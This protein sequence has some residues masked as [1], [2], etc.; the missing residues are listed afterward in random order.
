MI[1]ARYHIIRKLLI[2]LIAKALYYY[3]TPY[4]EERDF[5]F[6]RI[7]SLMIYARLTATVAEGRFDSRYE[8]ERDFTKFHA[9]QYPAKLDYIE[10]RYTRSSS[11]RSEFSKARTTT[12]RRGG[13]PQRENRPARDQLLRARNEISAASAVRSGQR[14]EIPLR[15]YRDGNRITSGF[16]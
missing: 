10:A 4:Y 3:Y 16:R 12:V 13:R 8:T 11:I 2:R 5:S 15:F 14:A 1:I 9:R 6:Y 7:T